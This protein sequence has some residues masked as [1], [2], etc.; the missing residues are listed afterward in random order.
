MNKKTEYDLNE[1]EDVASEDGVAQLIRDRC[2][3][4]LDNDEFEYLDIY[5][6][7]G[8]KYFMREYELLYRRKSDGKYFGVNYEED[9]EQGY[10][11]TEPEHLY[12]VKNVKAEM[13]MTYS[14]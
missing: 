2:D 10:H 8:C 5:E 14:W 3:F 11:N 4:E 9:V 12:E 7:E 1:F 13:K 6:C